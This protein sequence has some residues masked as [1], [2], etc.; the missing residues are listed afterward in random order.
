MLLF[1]FV[2]FLK[3]NCSLQIDATHE[4]LKPFTLINVMQLTRLLQHASA[5]YGNSIFIQKGK[6]INGAIT[7]LQTFRFKTHILFTTFFHVA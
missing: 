5:L 3:L 7:L 1:F 2:L 6:Q 4:G